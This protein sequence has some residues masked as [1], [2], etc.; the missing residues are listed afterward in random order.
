DYAASYPAP[1]FQLSSQS[2]STSQSNAS[3]TTAA[4]ATDDTKAIGTRSE[5]G[6]PPAAAG[7]SKSSIYGKAFELLD[8]GNSVESLIDPF[9]SLSFG[10]G[11]TVFERR[12]KRKGKE[13]DSE[14]IVYD[15]PVTGLPPV[16]DILKQIHAS[17]EQ[18]PWDIRNQCRKLT[19]KGITLVHILFDHYDTEREVTDKLKKAIERTEKAMRDISADFGE[20]AHMSFWFT[21]DVDAKITKHDGELGRITEFLSGPATRQAYDKVSALQE[22]LKTTASNSA[23]RKRAQEQLYSLRY[24]SRGEVA[25]LTAPELACECVRLGTQP[26][27]SGS[28]NE[29]WKGRWLDRQDVALIFYKEYNKSS[30]DSDSIRRFEREIKVWRRLDNPYVLRLYGWCKFDDETYLVSPWLPNGG[31]VKYLE[32]SG[33]RRERCLRLIYEIAQGLRYLHSHRIIHGSLRPSNV[34]IQDDGR[35]VLSDFTRVKIA[36]P[37][38]GHT[39]VNPQVNVFRYQAPEFILDQPIS[40]A[41]DVYSWA[42][43]AL[44]II[45]GSPPYRTW[46]SSGQLIAQVIAKA[47]IPNRSEY[48]SPVFNQ[49]PGIWVL[50]E[51]CWKRDQ[52]ARPTAK[53]I[54]EE[55]ERIPGL[56]R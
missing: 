49:H 53:E 13:I 34:L 17:M 21:H 26:E 27:Y 37:G 20:W 54:V 1:S 44:E 10:G 47:L 28:K 39:Q 22:V 31:V 43:T 52:T 8:D 32:A 7:S 18:M 2:A 50:F 14:T 40:S 19:T 16:V 38:A 5:F 25:D 46:R 12:V 36:P 24:L 29:I 35:A 51:R 15:M 41:C 48:D 56:R 42:M 6:K 4:A 3:P 55:L 30:R 9:G 33:G 45:T 23:D 11:N